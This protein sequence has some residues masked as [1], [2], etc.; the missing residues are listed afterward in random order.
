MA[1]NAA[2]RDYIFTRQEQIAKAITRQDSIMKVRPDGPAF[3]RALDQ[4]ISLESELRELEGDP[5]TWTQEKI[6]STL[7]KIPKSGGRRKRT[8]RKHKRTL[9]KHKRRTNKR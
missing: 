9:R 3:K 6:N 1:S 5:S 7:A 8:L 4:K 2:L